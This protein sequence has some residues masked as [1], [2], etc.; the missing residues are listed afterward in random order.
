MCTCELLIFYSM[1]MIFTDSRFSRRGGISAAALLH[2]SSMLEVPFLLFLWAT[3]DISRDRAFCC[4]L[5]QPLRKNT[6]QS[7]LQHMWILE[8]WCRIRLFN[9]TKWEERDPLQWIRNA[10]MWEVR[11]HMERKTIKMITLKT[12]TVNSPVAATSFP[13]NYQ[14]SV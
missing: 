11:R 13:H 1:P 10:Q 3:D 2:H 6:W 12:Q 5:V 4:N 8:A 9:M 7:V 14:L